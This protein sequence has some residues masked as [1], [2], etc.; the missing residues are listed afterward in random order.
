M[1]KVFRLQ[2]DSFSSWVFKQQ[3]LGKHYCKVPAGKLSL[4]GRTSLS[5]LLSIE[6]V[7]KGTFSSVFLLHSF[8]LVFH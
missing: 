1:E 4:G 7:E 6:N 2:N 3:Q 8:S 5:P